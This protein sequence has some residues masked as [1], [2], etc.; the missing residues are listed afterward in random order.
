MSLDRD[1][2]PEHVPLPSAARGGAQPEPFSDAP[3]PRAPGDAAI[4]R[5]RPLVVA[6]GLTAAAVLAAAFSGHVLLNSTGDRA[7]AL[8]I[9]RAPAQPKTPLPPLPP[10]AERIPAPAEASLTPPLPEPPETVA[11]AAASERIAPDG[12][13]VPFR[14]SFY[15]YNGALKDD[16]VDLTVD[17]VHRGPVSIGFA[18]SFGSK[19]TLFLTV[20]GSNVPHTIEYVYEWTA[21]SS[22]GGKRTDQQRVE[23][24][25]WSYQPGRNGWTLTHDTNPSGAGR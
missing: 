10:S 16:S 18:T 11:P 1:R 14:W 5:T 12:K 13:K 15:H 4:R 20:N 7:P 6:V 25:V 17:G 21:R 2:G 3:G 22:S 19:Q 8:A 24:D 9:Q 23:R